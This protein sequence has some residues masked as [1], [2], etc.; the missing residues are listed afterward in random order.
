M[1]RK[2]FN[3]AFKDLL[4][5]T[6]LREIEK[7]YDINRDS[8]T[9]LCRQEFPLESENRKKLEQI[10]KYNKANSS[11]KE[12][13]DLEMKNICERILQG[14]IGIIE[15][16]QTMGLHK[17]TFHEK[18]VDHINNSNSQSLK[19][20]YIEYMK[21]RKPDYSFIN[22]KALVIEMI[23]S[24]MSQS[25]IADEYGIPARTISREIEKLH[26]EEGYNDLYKIAKE[27]SQRK[28]KR[29]EFSEF[30]LFLVKNTLKDFDEGSVI[31]ADYIP[32]EVLEHRKN[33]EILQKLEQIDGTQKE[34]AEKLGISISTI[35]RAR[36]RVEEYEK[37]KK[38]QIEKEDEKGES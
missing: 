12:V 10:L 35:R 25:Q 30:E 26:N 32:K 17:Q 37:R 5:G 34:K 7:K 19:T 15:A 16:A 27:F 28:M 11:T 9:K 4:E 22:F 14:E 1:D 38:S 36:V 3:Q 24:N 8:F 31:I 33:K 13:T 18:L 2:I 21:K 20:R 6:S 23:D 29:E